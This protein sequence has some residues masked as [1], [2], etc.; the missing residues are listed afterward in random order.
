MSINKA[1]SLLV[2]LLF[3][4]GCGGGSQETNQQSD[5]SQKEGTITGKFSI[6]GAYA[7]YPL[8]RNWA[9]SFMK[10]NPGVTIEISKAGTG[11]G[12]NYL[13]AGTI[14][15]AMISRPLTE[16]EVEEGIW[17]VPVAKDGV[18]VIVNQK[19]PYLKR[20]FDQG[21]SP[22]ELIKVFINEKSITWGKLLDTVGLEKV[23]VFKRADESGAA[24]VFAG[25]LFKESTDL[26]GVGL[27][28]DEEMIKRV[29]ENVLSIGF[30]NFSYAFDA[31]S[32]DRIKDIQIIPIDLDFDN[33]I[34]RN[35]IP[36]SNL[37]KVHRG[38]WLGL[39]P[40]NLCRELFIGSYG[41]PTDKA[42]VEFL[43]YVISEGQ[44][45]VNESG[46]CELNNVYVRNSL[47]RLK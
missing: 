17:T 21:L 9:D 45:E 29:Q 18:A 12:I 40:K 32:G 43:M 1:T 22:D 25:F 33:K 6:S 34:E 8:V 3:L 4:F 15:L 23:S 39:Y 35:E 7:L 28:G 19:N 31:I 5:R 37:E 24:E 20:I 14:Q 16:A 44:N 13:L 47:E 42:I 38:L 46:L 11:E 27:N 41:K 2:S 10:I 36:F 26:I 30:C